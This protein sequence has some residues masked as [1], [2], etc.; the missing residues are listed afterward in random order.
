MQEP[1]PARC[2]GGA[3]A[4][5]FAVRMG[6]HAYGLPA[7]VATGHLAS[8]DPLDRADKVS[9][10]CSAVLSGRSEPR[11]SLLRFRQDVNLLPQLIGTKDYWLAKLFEFFFSSW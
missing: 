6:R 8:A 9:L 4:T 5:S 11:D 3:H 10:C 7:T 1:L 2:F